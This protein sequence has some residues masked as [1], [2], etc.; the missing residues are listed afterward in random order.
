MR[1]MLRILSTFRIFQLLIAI[2]LIQ[3]ITISTCF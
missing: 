2:Q 1:E 3:K